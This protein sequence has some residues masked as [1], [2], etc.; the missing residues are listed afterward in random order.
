M[1]VPEPSLKLQVLTS[2]NHGIQAVDNFVEEANETPEGRVALKVLDFLGKAFSSAFIYGMSM[3][4]AVAYQGV[5]TL[6]DLGEQS[7]NDARAGNSLWA[8]AQKVGSS[9]WQWG[10]G[11]IN[12]G[13]NVIATTA[14][15]AEIIENP[16]G[17]PDHKAWLAT[18]AIFKAITW[19]VFQ[20]DN[21]DKMQKE[22]ATKIAKVAITALILH[23][24]MLI[25]VQTFATIL[26]LNVIVL[27]LLYKGA[28]EMQKANIPGSIKEFR[29][30]SFTRTVLKLLLKISEGS[31]QLDEMA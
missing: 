21:V 19:R 9:A 16:K 26:L 28:V 18:L 7:I 10:I 17:I 14:L 29:P 5:S 2:I 27:P 30:D 3:P 6:V 15:W 25:S 12:S 20:T 13:K 23:A 22:L 4:I 8:K 31:A 1:A 11:K 24:F